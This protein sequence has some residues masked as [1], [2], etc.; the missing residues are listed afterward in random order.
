LIAEGCTPIVTDEMA[1]NKQGVNFSV[2]RDLAER[3]R[4]VAKEYY[5]KLGLCFSA[6]MLMFLEADP[7]TQG[8]YIKKMFD[9]EVNDEV[10]GAIA[11]AK[12]GQLKKIKAR[13]DGA[14][15]KRG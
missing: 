11:A 2:Q 13:E 10:E 8:E 12:A 4:E 15:G 5:G 3:F 6:A 7:Q 1:R 14:K 9:A